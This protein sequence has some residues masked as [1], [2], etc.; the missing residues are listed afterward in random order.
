MRLP[1]PFGRARSGAR[2]SAPPASAEAGASD[3]PASVPPRGGGAG[4]A[5]R[6]LPPLA[7]TIGPPPVVAPAAPFAASLAVDNPPPPIL[8]PLAHA[9]GLEAPSGIVVGV[10]KPVVAAH[11]AP[12]PA[13]VQR[14]PLRPRSSA[15]GPGLEPAPRTSPA[16]PL[17]VELARL[18]VVSDAPATPA[19]SLVTSSGAGISAPRGLV[20]PP[21]PAGSA[22]VAAATGIQGSPAAPQAAKPA[23]DRL[24][25]AAPKPA[26]VRPPG[27]PPRS[28]GESGRVTLGQARRLGLGAPIAGGPFARGGARAPLSSTS[29][30]PLVER[31]PGPKP[32]PGAG[33]RLDERPEP[34][35]Q[36]SRSAVPGDLS[37]A[38]EHR[39][40]TA[41]ISRAQEPARAPATTPAV[42]PAPGL[43]RS[44]TSSR[45]LP[46]PARP[47]PPARDAAAP[48]TSARPLRAGVQRAPLTIP[49]RTVAQGPGTGPGSDSGSGPARAV[50]GP[51]K[52]HRGRS[53]S[54]LATA[55]DA[56]S[57]THAGEI[58]LP[59]SHGSLT[60]GTGRSLLAHEL[61]HVAQQRRLGTALP[62][63]HTPHGQALEAEARSA[64]RAS[65]LPL[66]LPAT[67]AHEPVAA[68]EPESV[69]GA[70]RAPLAGSA[71]PGDSVST[72]HLATGTQRAPARAR[73]AQQPNGRKPEEHP[74]RTEQELEDL[75][76]QLYARIGRRLRRELFVDRERAGLALDLG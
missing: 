50:E 52:V 32:D 43:Q 44:P 51:V 18:P 14:S 60:S 13:A 33:V 74:A 41:A 38:L 11:G 37:P 28:E 72:V 68:P 76:G 69:H 12:M 34:L 45:P 19:R 64:E 5:W 17:P 22:S 42:A 6:S 20:L 62:Q 67:A 58:Y 23:A 47:A 61:A 39:P 75:A 8:A 30:L 56:R 59:D 1:W 9:R 49:A 70:Q 40:S 4:G 73:D 54:E 66:A 27:T 71:M 21:R 15:A 7:E 46:L 25:V 16:E 3:D 48:L 35:V 65:G 63:E 2:A 10:A 29:S 55:L 57:F 53:A 26:P 31:T 36:P 24:P